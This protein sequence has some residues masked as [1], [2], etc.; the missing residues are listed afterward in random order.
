VKNNGFYNESNESK[1][2][3]LK[4]FRFLQKGEK[5]AKSQILSQ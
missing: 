2:Q 1:E 3:I 5:H 4:E